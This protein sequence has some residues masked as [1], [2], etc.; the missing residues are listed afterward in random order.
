METDMLEMTEDLEDAPLLYDVI[1]ADG[2]LVS[3]N[4]A[5]ADAL[6]YRAEELSSKSAAT[7]Y[8]E[9]SLER[10][11]ALFQAGRNKGLD[12][13]RLTL[14]RRDRGV[15]QVVASA[16]LGELHGQPALRLAKL[17]LDPVLE[18]LEQARRELK[19]L[20]AFVTA[21]RDACWCI[22]FA[23]PVDLGASEQEIV[24][25]VFENECYWRLCNEA[26]AQLY[27]LPEGLDFNQENVRFVFPR[28]TENEAFVRQ[29]NE[30]KFHLDSAPS[31]DQRYD[32]APMFAENDVRAE[33]RDG[34]LLRMWGTVRD[35]SRQKERERQLT[36]RADR[37]AEVLSASPDPILVC[38][39]AGVLEA[40][41]PA[42]E[43]LFGW[44]VEEVLGRPI[45]QILRFEEPWEAIV[46]AARP[47]SSDLRLAAT[48]LCP[49]E[50]RQLCTVAIGSLT[51]A[52]E[53]RR[54]VATLRRR[55]EEVLAL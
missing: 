39:E 38:D 16:A 6:G 54:L 25:Q 37:M 44:K 35:L 20:R 13:E 29:L 40:A 47:A 52:D 30:A 4:R 12:Q 26:M 32:G 3:V 46:V 7:I 41:N 33:I 11:T 36:R 42:L 10:I 14:K 1:S 43:W 5:Q 9:A 19:V 23:E 27:R 48:L 28:N 49:D 53:A 22:E 31:L 17:R 15:I 51:L 50:R 24:R 8:T 45:A 21:S 18:E 55:D 34:Y 2:F